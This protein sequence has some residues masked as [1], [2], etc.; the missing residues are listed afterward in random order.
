MLHVAVYSIAGSCLRVRS[1]ALSLVL[2][3]GRTDAFDLEG[4]PDDAEIRTVVRCSAALLD[5]GSGVRIVHD[6]RVVGG[7]VDVYDSEGILARI[8]DAADGDFLGLG[9]A[10]WNEF[11]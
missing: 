6:E 10:P 2:R 5:G 11:G 9:V 7:E 1:D 4:V 8:F 3:G